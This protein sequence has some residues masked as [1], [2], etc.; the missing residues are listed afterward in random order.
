MSFD[1]DGLPNQKE[2]VKENILEPEWALSQ[3]PIR[4]SASWAID[5]EAIRG[6]GIIVLVK[7]S[8]LVKNIENK[9]TFSQLKLDFNPFLPPKSRRFSLLVGY[10][11]QPS[12]NSTNQNAALI[13][14]GPLVG[15]YYNKRY[16]VLCFRDQVLINQLSIVCHN[17]LGSL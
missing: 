10:N 4:P 5:S 13:M 2:I 8:Q 16:P 6:R 14:A 15:F 1:S 7:S 9:K 11:I 17:K 3:Q 12:S